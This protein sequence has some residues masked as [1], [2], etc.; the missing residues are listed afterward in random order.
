MDVNVRAHVS[1][2][3][4]KYLH[5]CFCQ[6]KLEINLGYQSPEV[7][8]C[9]SCFGGV[10]LSYCLRQSLTRTLGSSSKVQWLAIESWDLP[11]STSLTLRLHEATTLGFLYGSWGL[12]SGPYTWACKRFTNGIIPKVTIIYFYPY[13][14]QKPYHTGTIMP[15]SHMNKLG[16]HPI[17]TQVSKTIRNFHGLHPRLLHFKWS[18]LQPKAC[19]RCHSKIWIIMLPCIGDNYLALSSGDHTHLAKS[20][21]ARP[22]ALAC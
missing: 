15:V 14:I 7:V 5:L 9:V 1:A 6:R 12:S 4:D 18:I 16:L 10:L 13:P 8:H 20:R 22:D 19:T 2:C 21:V 17:V 3:V 11:V